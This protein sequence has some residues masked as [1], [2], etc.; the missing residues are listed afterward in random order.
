MKFVVILVSFPLKKN[1]ELIEIKHNHQ[2]TIKW[3]KNA[4]TNTNFMTKKLQV[5]VARIYT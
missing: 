2:F 4:K 3:M 5:D 1:V